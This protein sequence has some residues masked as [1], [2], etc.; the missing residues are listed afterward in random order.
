MS[1]RSESVE[2]RSVSRWYDHFRNAAIICAALV[3]TV[4]I[5]S[6]LPVT[7]MD[8]MD[9]FRPTAVELETPYGPGIFNPPWLFVILHPLT[10]LDPRLGASLLIVA[11]L[12]IISAYVKAPKKL[13]LVACS[14]PLIALVTLGQI[15]GL[16]ILGLMLPAEIGLVWLMMKPQG[17]FLVALRRLSFRSVII[18]GAV[19]VLSILI[20][21]FWWQDVLLFRSLTDTGHN[22][23]L[24]PYTILLG[25][26]LI[27]LGLKRD[28]DALLCLASLCFSPYFM[29]TSTLPA[30]AAIVRESE[31]RRVWFITIIGSWVF[32]FLTKFVL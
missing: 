20:W 14:A 7:F 9:S 10:W 25:L 6:L 17:V 21:G 24:F 12:V 27:Y 8:W 3:F 28:S 13:L 2:L 11:S 32:F 29:I 18:A 16:I 4:L 23:S 22:V 26:P 1:T 5:F 30:V 15:D 19:F 31:D